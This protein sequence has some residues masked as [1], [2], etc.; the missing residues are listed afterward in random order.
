MKKL[1]KEN[2][3]TVQW[4]YK[5]DLGDGIVTPGYNYQNV[6]PTK[7][8]L[9]SCHLKDAY[10]LDIGVMEGALSV[11]MER[12]GAKVVGYDRVDWTDKIGLVKETQNASFDY[13]GGKT[14]HNFAKQA[15]A[16]K[17]A[18]FDIV[19]M[20]GV[21]Y[22]TIDPLLFLYYARCMMAVGST[23]VIETSAVTDS[24]C[25]MQFNNAGRFYS[26]TNY[27]QVSTGWLDYT[28]R[29][30]GFRI[31]DVSYV[32]AGQYMYG[33][34]K[35]MHVP[36][37]ALRCV[38]TGEQ[39]LHADD[40]WGRKKLMM[41]ELA[42]YMAIETYP[43]KDP[44]KYADQALNPALPVHDGVDSV[45]VTAAIKATKPEARD[46]EGTVLTLDSRL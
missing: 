6:V 14:F 4:Y 25:L 29:Y 31:L 1:S 34:N 24:E 45:D 20:S 13:Y 30:L 22:H 16:D 37:V 17:L 27:Y 18:P 40:E 23:F 38:L 36:R 42:E 28:L 15:Q 21:L 41:R 33:E 5:I 3:D 39:Q 9:R 11:L 44:A 32:N 35:D 7:K 26:F 10:L 8:L 2:F 19:V 46:P 43:A 12:E